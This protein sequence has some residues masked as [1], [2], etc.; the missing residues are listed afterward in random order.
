MGEDKKEIFEESI[1]AI[2]TEAMGM[3]SLVKSLLLLA[4]CDHG[5]ELEME[6]FSLNVLIGELIRDSRLIAPD[7]LITYQDDT[8]TPALIHADRDLIKQMLR[9]LI[10]NSVNFTPTN[11]EI[12]IKLTGDR[13]FTVISIRDNGIGI[14]KDELGFIFDRFY[15]VD[16]SRTRGKS[17]CGLGLSIV[18]SIIDLHGGKIA[19]ES[20]PGVGTEFKITLPEPCFFS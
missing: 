5:L 4:K 13:N 19:V 7:R 14:P 1:N 15:C 16:K 3:T 9:A 2:I 11:G 10:E 18:R 8:D 6:T 12:T 17:G 20:E